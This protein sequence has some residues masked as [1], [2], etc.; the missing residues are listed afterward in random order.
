MARRSTCRRK[1]PSCDISRSLKWNSRLAE[2]ICARSVSTPSPTNRFWLLAQTDRL[3]TAGP[4]RLE[5]LSLQQLAYQI[6]LLQFECVELGHEV[7][8][9]ARIRTKPSVCSVR[10]ASRRVLLDNFSLSANSSWRR[11]WPG[12]KLTPHDHV[13]DGRRRADGCIPPPSVAID[14]EYTPRVGGTA[15]KGPTFGPLVGG[16]SS[17]HLTNVAPPPRSRQGDTPRRAHRALEA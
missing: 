8:T 7:A 6:H 1:R 12:L 9:V 3:R 10:R 16:V 14:A 5:E 4:D 17:R 15:P 13:S 2:S 11:G